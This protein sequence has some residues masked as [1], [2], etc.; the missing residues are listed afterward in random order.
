MTVTPFEKPEPLPL[1]NVTAANLAS[2]LLAHSFATA[3][4]CLEWTGHRDKNGYGAIT[5]NQRP[6]RTHRVA[7]EIVN[8]PIPSGLWVLHR[9]DNPP[10]MNPDHLFM[11]TAADNTSDMTGTVPSDD[12]LRERIAETIA[13]F[14]G[15]RGTESGWKPQLE[16]QRLAD[17]LLPLIR[18]YVQ[19]AQA[20]AEC[21]ACGAAIGEVCLPSCRDA[22]S[23]DGA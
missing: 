7:W 15:H 12:G 20:W 14:W 4:G 16:H 22:L 5:I 23:G 21:D 3:T 1:P 17:A 6:H 19:K 8:G 10:C 18:E 11:G 2:R 13:D 9:C